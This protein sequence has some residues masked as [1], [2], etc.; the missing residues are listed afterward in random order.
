MILL[1]AAVALL[2]VGLSAAG[3]LELMQ[4]S[5][6]ALREARRWQTAAAL[7]ESYA[8]AALAGRQREL[9]PPFSPPPGYQVTT[10]ERRVAPRLDEVAVT[11]VLPDGQKL[12]VRRLARAR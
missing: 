8:E 3:Y 5:S 9:L 2:I 6:Q 4:A 12:V 10:E 7:A 1:E 11:V